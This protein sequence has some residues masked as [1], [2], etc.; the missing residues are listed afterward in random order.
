MKKNLLFVVVLVAAVALLASCKK[1]EISMTPETTKV[2]GS[3]AA[4]FEVVDEPVKVAL[5]DGKLDE[6]ESVWSVKLRRTDAALPFGDDCEIAPYGSYRTDGSSY[7][8]AGFGLKIKDADGNVVQENEAVEGGLSGP[9]SSDDVKALFQLK[10]GEVGEIRW[11]VD[12]RCQDAKE[13][14][15]FTISSAHNS[16][17]GYGG[18][19]GSCGEAG[20]GD[21]DA[22]LNQ[23]EN[24]I[25]RLSKLNW[26][27]DNYDAV[28]KQAINLYDKLID[29][30]MSSEQEKRFE[31][32]NK[33]FDKA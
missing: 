1:K 2:S 5:K 3:L 32:L 29:M 13:P 8:L 30:E 31:E 9:Y 22:L 7:C 26:L 18:N 16:V 14:L 19:S 12:S 6:M 21:V 24:T 33:K 4:C 20:S 27:D 25:N 28:E 15:K 10:A 11:T 23:F 17:D